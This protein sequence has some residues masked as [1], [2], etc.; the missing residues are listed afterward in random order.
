MA[1]NLRES[2]GVIQRHAMSS[3]HLAALIRCTLRSGALSRHT[4]GRELVKY[5]LKLRDYKE[6]KSWDL[7][8]TATTETGRFLTW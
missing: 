1:V 6:D 8:L 4:P 7:R 3:T 2:R 5:Q